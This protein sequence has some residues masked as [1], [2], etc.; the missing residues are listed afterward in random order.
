MNIRSIQTNLKK[1]QNDNLLKFLY[2][3][4]V[5]QLQDVDP[6][7]EGNSYVKDDV[8]YLQEN[9]IHKIYQCI[10]DKSSNS[11]VSDEWEHILDTYDREIKTVNNLKIREEVHIITEETKSQIT[12]KLDFKSENSTFIVYNGKKR[13]A[14]NHDFTVNEKTITFNKPFN[15]GDRLILEVRESI[16]LPDRLVLL[17]TNGIKYEVGVIGE[18][19]YIFESSHRTS[20][21]E[22]YIKDSMNGTNYKI[23]MIDD[24]LYYEV[25]D[26]NVSK[27]EVKIMDEEGNEFKIE[28][29]NDELMVSA[30]E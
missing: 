24:D 14:V 15:V 17:S 29:V 11:F 18:D 2:D 13:Y 16:G 20:K 28:M 8:V 25:T 21:N 7:K 6:Y 19:V 9:N 10:V 27:T 26:I 5:N 23:H 4:V 30:K 3:I 22:V 12:S 1:L